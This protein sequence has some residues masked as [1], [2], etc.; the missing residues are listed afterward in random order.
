M[1]KA[2]TTTAAATIDAAKLQNSNYTGK[3]GMYIVSTGRREMS[4]NRDFAAL[5]AEELS[6]ADALKDGIPETDPSVKRV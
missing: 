3:G 4:D 2:T 1:K 6:R 5:I